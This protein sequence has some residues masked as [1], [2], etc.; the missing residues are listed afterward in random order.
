MNLY[1]LHMPKEYYYS[2]PTSQLSEVGLPAISFSNLAPARP[3]P[4]DSL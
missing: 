3:E 2:T 4:T 1:I